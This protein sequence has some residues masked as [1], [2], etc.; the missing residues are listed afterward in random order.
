MRCQYFKCGQ[1]SSE[2]RETDPEA[3]GGARRNTLAVRTVTVVVDGYWTQPE[4]QRSAA[5][6]LRP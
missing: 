4:P 5:V 6:P 1:V 3:G 2:K